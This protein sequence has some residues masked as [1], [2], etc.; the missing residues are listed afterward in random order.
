MSIHDVFA[1]PIDVP[2]ELALISKSQHLSRRERLIL[3][4]AAGEMARNHREFFN[5]HTELVE[6]RRAC[7]AQAERLLEL[8]KDN[9][10]KT[11]ELKKFREPITWGYGCTISLGMVA[12]FPSWSSFPAIQVLYHD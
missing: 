10:A 3:G 7:A 5:M 2:V 8:K 1:A 4:E 9:D 11:V 12:R 6:T